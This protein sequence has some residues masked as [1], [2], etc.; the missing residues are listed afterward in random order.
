[1]QQFLNIL[2]KLFILFN[3]KPFRKNETI[4]FNML[5]KKK[6]IDGEKM[7]FGGIQILS[8]YS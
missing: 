4:H 8:I 1:M 5:T 2:L 7:Q 3:S 6:K